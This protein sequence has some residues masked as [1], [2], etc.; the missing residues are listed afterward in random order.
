MPEWKKIYKSTTELVF[1]WH[2]LLGMGLL[3][4]CWIDPVK[5]HWGKLS[6]ALGDIFL[7][8]GRSSKPLSLLISRM[9]S[10]LKLPVLCLL[11]WS[12][13]VHLYSSPAVYRRHWFLGVIYPLWHLQS[14]GLLFGIGP[15]VLRGKLW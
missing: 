9:S 4:V 6:L 15:C 12:L 3:Y 10:S 5:L 14:F 2:P 1:R 13:W 8:R 7:V 11:S